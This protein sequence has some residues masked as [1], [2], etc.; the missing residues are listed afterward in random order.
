MMPLAA[1]ELRSE[2]LSVDFWQHL[3]DFDPPRQQR[4]LLPGI[5]DPTQAGSLARSGAGCD[6]LQR[7]EVRHN[8]DVMADCG[9]LATVHRRRRYCTRPMSCCCSFGRSCRRSPPPPPR[10]AA[11]DPPGRTRQWADTLGSR[12][13]A[14]VPIRPG[15]RETAR[16]SGRPRSA[17]RRPQRAGLTLGGTVRHSWPLLRRTAQME[18]NLRSIISRRRRPRALTA[19]PE[20][21]NAR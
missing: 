16:H 13:S 15:D 21:S 19:D 3:V 12:S 18:P 8:Y 11:C 6:V 5:S 4:L 7:L 10:C 9:R 20:A 14:K 2:R 17:G 1:A